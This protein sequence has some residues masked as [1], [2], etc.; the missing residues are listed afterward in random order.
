MI[1]RKISPPLLCK[2]RPPRLLP[3]ALLR[4]VELDAVQSL[5]TVPASDHCNKNIIIIIINI[6]I[7][8]IMFR[9]FRPSQPPITATTR[10]MLT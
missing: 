2:P 9:A 5:P 1:M 7:I 10:S 8:I 3:L 6:I 4:V